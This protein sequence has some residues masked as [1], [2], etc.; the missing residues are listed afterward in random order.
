MRSLL[1]WLQRIALTVLALAALA[2]GAALITAHTGWGREQLRSAIEDELRG[3]FPGGARLASIDGSVLGTLT[4]RGVELDGR[5]HR[6]VVTVTALRVSVALWPLAVATARLDSLIADGVHVFVRD[7]PPAPDRPRPPS[8]WRVEIPA[9][10]VHRAAVAI[11]PAGVTLD[12]LDAAGAVTIADGRVTVSGAVHGRLARAGRPA[13]ELTA[14]GSAVVDGGVRIPGAIAVV[15][16]AALVAS[17]LAIDLDHPAGSITVAAPA[18]V[19]EAQ[20]PELGELGELGAAVPGDVAATIRLAADGAATRLSIRAAAGEARLWAALRGEPARWTASGLISATAVDLGAATGGRIAGRGNLIAALDAGP[21]RARGAL[22]AYGELAAAGVPVHVAGVAIAGSLDGATAVALGTGDAG[23]RVV[24]VARGHHEARAI[25]VDAAR[26]IATAEGF[27]VAGQRITGALALDAATDGGFALGAA[28]DGGFALGAPARITGA[29]VGRGVTVEPE[30][31][32][33][34]SDRLAIG[35]VRAPFELTLGGTAGQ[36]AI[37][38][39]I[40]DAR[41]TAVARDD[42]ALAVAHGSLA[43][44]LVSGAGPAAARE[45]RLDAAHLVA[46]RIRR[47]GSALGDA[48]VDLERRGAAYRIAA[49]VQ[50]PV[51]GLAIAARALVR[52]AGAGYSAALDETS[53]RLPD[54]A[55]WAGRG[56]SLDIPDAAGAPIR[57][58]DLAL[59]RGEASLALAGSYA[60]A[61]GELTAHAGAERI[62]PAALGPGGLIAGASGVGRATLDLTRRGGQWQA[63]ASLAVSELALAPGATPLDASAHLVLD[64]RGAT[65][66]ARATG[67]AFGNLGLALDV[68][69]PRDPFDLA[70]WRRLDRGAIRSA[71]VTAHGVAV[72]GLAGGLGGAPA[73]EAIPGTIDGSVDLAP[74]ALRGQLTVRGVAVPRGVPGGVSG[75]VIDGDLTFAPVDGDLGAHAS[76]RLT[77]VAAAELTARLAL[78]EHPFD[79]DSWRRG[80]ELLREATAT[81]ADVAFDPGLLAQLGAAAG[82]RALAALPLSGHLGARLAVGAAAR[83]ARLTV[84]LSGVTGG[85]LGAPVSQRAE[86]TAGPS[87]SHLHAELGGGGAG[88]G[89]LRLGTLDADVPMTVDRWLAEPAAVLRAPLTAR[90]TLD[91]TPLAPVLALL[92]RRELAAGTL[93]G[94]ATIGGTVAAPILSSAQPARLIARDVRVSPR[95]GGRPVP[96]V[97]TLEVAA[98]WGGA[99]GTLE[100]HGREAT[101]G[102]LEARLNGRPDAL[103]A[104]T[105]TARL[106]RLDVAPVAAFLPGALASAAGVVDGEIALRPGGRVTGRLH[107]A[108]GALPLAAA[109]GTLRDATADITSDGSAIHADLHGRLGR[110]TIDVG[111]DAPVDLAHATAHVTLRGVSPIAALRPVISAELT[112]DL[113]RAADQLRGSVTVADGASIA[114]PS[115]AGTPLLDPAVPPDLVLAGAPVARP[116]DPRAPAHPWLVV[117][118]HAP[119]IR[120][121]AHDLDQG[122]GVVGAVIASVQTD[123][124]EV[125]IGDTVGVTGVVQLE[126]DDVDI[127]GRRYLVE[128]VRDGPSRLVFDGTLD[129]R[130]TIAMSYPFPDLTLHV[131]LS[132]RVSK[133]DPPRFSSDPPGLYTQDQLFGFFLGA[134]PNTDPGSSARDPARGAVAGGGTRLLAAKIGAQL[135]K[136]LPVE[137]K[138][139]LSC[140]PDPTATTTT[141]GSCTAGRW[142]RIPWLKQRAYVVSRY[143]PQPHPDENTAEAQVQF[144]LPHGFL[145]QGSD[146]DRGYLDA[147][148]LW[149]HRW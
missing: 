62:D 131:D 115:R 19:I 108:G 40:R 106:T 20:I 43:L 78:P 132:G 96:A 82:S 9:L 4:L 25:V 70:A 81:A 116:R 64:R 21:D 128:P 145:L 44:G 147:D 51:P 31:A 53:V 92:G 67:P 94:S 15:D 139:D 137:L 45:P 47:A 30:P 124:L 54:G 127:L 33:A 14:G 89:A 117:E 17:A 7:Q 8:A 73:G 35:A 104:A 57:L 52:R 105:G 140:E 86:L 133:P 71:A 42:L 61:S 101:G 46:T 84:E 138:F 13:A 100:V 110:G 146:G 111:A 37:D 26:A 99:S 69:A 130:I 144:R 113:H 65:L 63:D 11:E 91:P 114:L 149:R 121:E 90:W 102:A 129:P 79:P 148:L 38:V 24:A 93:E 66:D 107:V 141:L 2:T 16:G 32:A 56:G 112:A 60:R 50:P 98:T 83:D 27:A 49:T 87:G 76:A 126:S 3:A 135:N 85:P 28:T 10:E 74:S 103:A 143:R 12:G 1:R 41:A 18:A 142:V 36:V 120:F 34:R 29:V 80:R 122:V 119:P 134:E 97:R 58:V 75:G 59:H 6:P 48:R 123:R 39:A 68:A 109:V 125:A 22:I 88:D 95:L 23:L 55:V 118:V 77:G 5:D 72:A 136:V